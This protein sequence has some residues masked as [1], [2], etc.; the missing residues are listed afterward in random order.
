MFAPRR[1]RLPGYTLR[2]LL[3]IAAALLITYLS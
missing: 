2:R 1:Y 3:V